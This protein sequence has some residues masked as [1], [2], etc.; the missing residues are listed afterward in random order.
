MSRV[1]EGESHKKRKGK[2]MKIFIGTG[3]KTE[4]QENKSRRKV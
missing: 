4:R 2:N 1:K 3:S